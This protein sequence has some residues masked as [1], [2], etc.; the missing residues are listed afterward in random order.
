MYKLYKV[1]SL[2]RDGFG[3]EFIKNIKKFKD[4]GVDLK[5]KETNKAIDFVK[6][7]LDGKVKDYELFI[8]TSDGSSVEVKG[9]EVD[10]FNV[11]SNCGMGLRILKDSRPG[12]SF[13]TTFKEDSLSNMVERA[14]S[15]AKAVEEDK[16]YGIFVEP[17][18]VTVND[19]E[20]SLVDKDFN[21]VTEDKCAALALQIEKSVMEYDTKRIKTVRKASFSKSIG[22]ARIINSKG[23]D[24]HTRGTY[25][26]GSVVAVAEEDGDSQMGW[27]ARMSRFFKDIDPAVI[28]FDAGKRAVSILNADNAKTVKCPVVLENLVVMEFLGTL[29]SSFKGDNVFKGKSMLKDKLGKGVFSDKLSIV[30][31]GLLKRGWGSSP[32][33]SEGS[34]SCITPL[35]IKGVV[36]NFLYDTYWARRAGKT[37]TGNGVRGGIKDAVGIGTSNFFIEEGKKSFDDLLISMDDGIVITDVMGTHTIDAISGDFSLGATGFRVK[38]GVITNPLKGMAIAGNLIDMFTKIEE[39]G[40]D[41]R[42]MGSTGAPSLLI[43]SLDISG[44]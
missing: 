1:S 38:G 19:E 27:D 29:A 31:N 14:I 6:N 42:F 41:T 26:S 33:D 35:V 24:V 9:G 5:N 22:E 32:F 39:V 8:S 13:S 15:G 20:L 7:K 43:G 21:E 25:F 3:F 36:T 44:S 23:I 4:N 30:D 2:R 10:A 16:D 28:G 34:P 37:P 40:S 12:F 18:D 17:S 11:S